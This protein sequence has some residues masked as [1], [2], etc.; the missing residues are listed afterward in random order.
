[1]QRHLPAVLLAAIIL[2]FSIAAPANAQVANP[3]NTSQS[4]A[5]RCFV[6]NA[7]ATKILTVP[8]GMNI[9]VYDNYAVAVFRITQDTDLWMMMLGTTSAIADAMPAKNADGTANSIAQTDAIN[10]IVN[11]ESLTGIIVIPSQITLAQLE[12]FAQ[13]TVS[14]ITGFTGV[15]LSPGA[16]LRLIDSYIITA[17]SSSGTINWT[18]VDASLTTA[19][20]NLISSGMVKMPGSVTQAQFTTFVEDV[21]HAIAAYKSATG[22]KSL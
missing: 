12:M 7:I 16:V 3:C 21:A 11:S 9:T 13:Q 18:T 19:V 22:R 6:R 2:I 10:S 20:K 14:N 8:T 5:V 4:F 1:V 15:S 17:T